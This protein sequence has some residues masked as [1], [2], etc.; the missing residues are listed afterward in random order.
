VT[1]RDTPPLPLP[2]CRHTFS[3]LQI[4][5]SS[6]LST[7]IPPFPTP[8]LL[9]LNNNQSTL[10]NKLSSSCPY[11]GGYISFCTVIF[12]ILLYIQSKNLDNFHDHNITGSL[13][14]MRTFFSWFFCLRIKLTL[15]LSLFRLSR[16]IQKEYSSSSSYFLFF[17]FL[18][19]CRPAAWAPLPTGLRCHLG[20]L[21]RPVRLCSRSRR[22]CAGPLKSRP[23][24]YQAG[25]QKAA[26]IARAGCIATGFGGP[27][28]AACCGFGVAGVAACCGLGGTWVAACC[29]LGGA[30]V[31]ACCGLG[32]AGVA[33]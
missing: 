15:Q 33:S 27:G 13:N 24:L 19:Y 3:P 1:T 6:L 8:S 18:R 10:P 29:G 12:T 28:V 4:Q 26:Q 9:P 14:V 25:L 20:R 21:C 17:K 22:L 2:P 16:K 32:G 7:T 31:A 23:H 30:G 5:P 11:I